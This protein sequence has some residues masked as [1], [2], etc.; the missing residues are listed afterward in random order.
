MAITSVKAVINGQ[1][2][3][4]TYNSTDKTYQATINAPS[5][6]SFN[7]TGGFYNV[8]VTANDNSGNSTTVDSSDATLGNS[9]KLYV[10]EKTAPVI[11]N[12]SIASGATLVNNTPDISFNV[13]DNDSGV[14]AAT[15][16][17]DG[18]AVSGLTKTAITGGYKYS[19]KP[20]T[21]L[22]DG[23]HTIAIGAS[24]NDENAATEVSVSFKVDTTPPVLNVSAPL[25]DSYTNQTQINVVGVTN[26]AI[27]SPVTVSIGVN[28]TDAGSVTVNANGSFTKAVTLREGANTITI[29]STDKAG[30]SST[31]TRTVNLNTV[32]PVFTSV[33]LEPN[34]VD[35]GETYIIKVKV[36]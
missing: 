24:D 27:S 11:S 31:I 5:R 35:A 12:V 4:L 36:S 10:K 21:A 17:I 7:Q 3:T 23:S 13:T 16:K 25:N 2:Y 1:E 6:S 8:A 19:Y 9:L 30:K 15:L 22:A 14:K 18:T 32:A 26:D 34:P 29:T 20:T 33:E 28:G